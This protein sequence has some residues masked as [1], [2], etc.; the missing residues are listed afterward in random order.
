V[1]HL[2]QGA[3]A[4]DAAKDFRPQRAFDARLDPLDELLAR[5]DVDTGVKVGHGRSLSHGV[6]RWRMARRV[7]KLWYFT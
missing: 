7:G 6:P 2:D 3:E 1:G 4:A 5:V